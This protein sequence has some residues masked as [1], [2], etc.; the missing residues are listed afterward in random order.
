[1]CI[2]LFVSTVSLFAK[3]K[4]TVVIGKAVAEV[5]NLGMGAGLFNAS[6]I[7][8]KLRNHDAN[9]IYHKNIDPISGQFTAKNIQPG[10]YTIE[11][12]Q[13]SFSRG[14]AQ[15]SISVYFD[16]PL[17]FEVEA[18]ELCVLDTHEMYI[19]IGS[20]YDVSN[21]KFSTQIRI[22]ITRKAENDV[23]IDNFLTKH[24]AEKWQDLTLNIV[25]EPIK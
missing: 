17:T 12:Y 2:I 23:L 4:P 22:D 21:G 1:M 8:V 18:G 25:S 14:R 7:R 3:T 16:V 5:F 24:K 9:R 15:Y 11:G 20:P 13:V 10:T 6:N 19:E